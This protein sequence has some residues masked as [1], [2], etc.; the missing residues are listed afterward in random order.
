MNEFDNI[1]KKITSLFK[2]IN[3]KNVDKESLIEII[4]L[5]N[6]LKKNDLLEQIILELDKLSD[7]NIDNVDYQIRMESLIKKFTEKKYLQKIENNSCKLYEYNEY[8]DLYLT[9]KINF[10]EF[11]KFIKQFEISLIEVF[12]KNKLKYTSIFIFKNLND[13]ENN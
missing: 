7:N 2:K 5:Y 13:L 1:K 4:Y 6:T 3:I 9:K 10:N 11:F 8:Y 12:Q